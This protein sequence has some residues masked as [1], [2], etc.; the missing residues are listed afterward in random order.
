MAEKCPTCGR[1]QRHPLLRNYKLIKR[2]PSE[3]F[4]IAYTVAT[5]GG[6]HL[7]I[8]ERSLE[9]LTGMWWVWIGQTKIEAD[10]RCAEGICYGRRRDAV[11]RILKKT[12][13]LASPKKQAKDQ[14]PPQQ[15]PR[16]GPSE[17]EAMRRAVSR[18]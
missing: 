10:L 3:G 17:I 18:G 15:M 8:I 5:L 13:V 1:V 11:L 12:S 16:L 9:P 7:G 14:N 2:L 6:E 4:R